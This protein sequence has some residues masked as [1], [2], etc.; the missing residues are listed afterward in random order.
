[1]SEN[2]KALRALVLAASGWLGGCIGATDS[3]PQQ[4]AVSTSVEALSAVDQCVT[5]PRDQQLTGGGEF[6]T[7][8]SYA[9][10]GTGCEN[11]YL[12]DLDNYATKYNLGTTVMFAGAQPTDQTTCYKA[13]IRA[14]VWERFSNGGKQFLG[15]YMRSGSWVVDSQD[16][17]HCILPSLK[18]E[19]VIP[20]FKANGSRDFRI[21]MR[22]ELRSADDT[23]YTR[24]EIA[25]ATVELKNV[26]PAEEQRV[27]VAGLGS[28]LGATPPGQVYPALQTIWNKKNT[29]TGGVLCRSTQLEHTLAIFNKRSLVKAGAS[30]FTVDSRANALRDM[31]TAYCTPDG[32]ALA[33][34]SALLSYLGSTF[35]ANGQ[36]REK[37]FPQAPDSD[38][39]WTE[40]SNLMG[41]LFYTDLGTLVERCNLES[42]PVTTFL[43]SGVLPRGVTADRLLLGS[44]GDLQ[45]A[46]VA[47]N[48]GVGA[49][50][51]GQTA[52][53]SRAAFLTCMKPPDIAGNGRDVCNDPRAQGGGAP[54]TNEPDG[55]EDP[56]L[57]V[58]E[59]L[60]GDY[61]TP[62]TEEQKQKV[63][64]E[65]LRMKQEKA[66]R[67]DGEQKISKEN[68]GENPAKTKAVGDAK[69]DKDDKVLDAVVE[70]GEAIIGVSPLGDAKDWFDLTIAIAKLNYLTAPPGG[71]SKPSCMYAPP[72]AQGICGLG[73]QM[74]A[75]DFAP[76][77]WY[78]TSRPEVVV[79]GPRLPRELNKAD[80]LSHCLC[81][82]M[83]A[84]YGVAGDR[85]AISAACP[86]EEERERHNCIMN[87]HGPHGEIKRDCIKHLAPALDEDAWRAK[88][89]H[90]VR[91]PEQ[92]QVPFVA[93]DGSCDCGRIDPTTGVLPPCR[94]TEIALCPPDNPGPCFCQPVDNGMT[95]NGGD[96]FCGRDV[97]TPG[98]VG[99][100]DALILASP[101]DAF[102]HQFDAT[103]RLLM[104]RPGHTSVG[105]PTF[106]ENTLPNLG[107]ALRTEVVVGARPAVG[108]NIDLQVYCTNVENNLINAYMGECRLNS[109]TPGA[110]GN[111]DI[112][113]NASVLAQC[114]TGDFDLEYVLN[115]AS[116]YTAFTGISKASFIGTLTQTPTSDFIPACPRPSPTSGTRL[117][118]GIN[119]TWLRLGGSTTTPSV[120]WTL[121]SDLV[122]EIPRTASLIR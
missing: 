82:V 53:S 104:V 71:S 38:E 44:C 75:P 33:L 118:G 55:D 5:T 79:D 39:A 50:F 68:P 4:I 105:L 47:T 1:M 56:V 27:V 21:G 41:A 29:Y 54:E 99:A 52:S 42:T 24:K 43:T 49:N 114:R 14:Y 92:G 62:C 69:E 46:T 101:S 91:C 90:A 25:F 84:E 63:A 87:P 16:V 37:L 94:A 15:Q 102:V 2:A 35:T 28:G 17:G 58:D 12:L 34:Q 65:I 117:V 119:P 83:I 88:A 85:S 48:L 18:L 74:C 51:R 122:A 112:Q 107:T 11:G 61:K 66:Q 67:K 120:L 19:K 106:Y 30:A 64:L 108:Q 100:K 26:T 45:A 97:T 57:N 59:C 8:T 72:A 93:G 96:P 78:E 109:L 73:N 110:P 22:A 89:C 36:I 9:H 95:P 76:G 7:N 32:T 103:R 115:T 40:V 116:G 13:K 80:R 86:T 98:F 121:S 3:E 77:G 70:L 20:N 23:T 60:Q 31:V 81:D 10:N 113:L 6:I 111:C